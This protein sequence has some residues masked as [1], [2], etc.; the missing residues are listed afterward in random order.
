MQHHPATIPASITLP[1]QFEMILDTELHEMR[2]AVLSIVMTESEH[3][4]GLIICKT[5]SSVIII[6]MNIIMCFPL[7][8]AGRFNTEQK[9][10]TKHKLNNVALS[11]LYNT[12]WSSTF[13]CLLQNVKL[14]LPTSE[15]PNYW[16]SFLLC[17]EKRSWPSRAGVR[18]YSQMEIARNGGKGW[19]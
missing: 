5:Y 14:L 12:K 4:M 3:L 9:L 11:F 2:Q 6:L 8:W 1:M 16:R 15:H 18:D 7:L 19:W 10:V 13:H 17:K